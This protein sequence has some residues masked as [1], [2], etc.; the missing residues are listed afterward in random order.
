MR[1]S[2]IILTDRAYPT[3]T[4]G[5]LVATAYPAVAQAMDA[6]PEPCVG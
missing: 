6:W 1:A 3:G 2:R 4:A 5:G